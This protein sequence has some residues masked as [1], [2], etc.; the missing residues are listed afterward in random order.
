M[1]WWSVILRLVYDDFQ[2]F[3]TNYSTQHKHNRSFDKHSCKYYVEMFCVHFLI[4]WH[5]D[6]DTLHFTFKLIHTQPVESTTTISDARIHRK[7]SHNHTC[8]HAYFKWSS[9]VFYGMITLSY[10]GKCFCYHLRISTCIFS[11]SF[12]FL[13]LS[14][15][16]Q[17][18]K[19]THC[20]L[21][22][23]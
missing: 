20:L 12:L 15:W 14:I 6:Y 7:F 10:R 21:N 18:Q 22:E 4:N 8:M 11:L 1:F 3:C 5:L 2:F 19:K 17:R 16:I 9:I 13:L 23:L